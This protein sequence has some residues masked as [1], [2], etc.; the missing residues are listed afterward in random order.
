MAVRRDRTGRWRYRKMVRLPDGSKVRISG[1]PT[2]NTK[3][4]AER[5]ER[6]HIER[7]LN[8]PPAPPEREEVETATIPIV[9]E[10]ATEFL[11]VYVEVNNKPSEIAQKKL[12]FR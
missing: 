5:E 4:E 2:M 7:V 6:V 8:P 9:Q 3:V 10:F 12:I 1:C 11:K